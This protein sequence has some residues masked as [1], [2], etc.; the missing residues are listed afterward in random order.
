[1]QYR[2]H[3]LFRRKRSSLAG[4]A[5]AYDKDAAMKTD[6]TEENTVSNIIFLDDKGDS[7]NLHEFFPPSMQIVSQ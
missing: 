1:M 7:S 4:A 5:V 6:Q 3:Y 2:Y